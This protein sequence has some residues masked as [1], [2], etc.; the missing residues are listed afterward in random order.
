M[1]NHM[2]LASLA[3]VS[4]T[5][6]SQS[7]LDNKLDSVAKTQPVEA[8]MPKEQ[9]VKVVV[10]AKDDV[11]ITKLQKQ[12]A[13]GKMTKGLLT[14]ELDATLDNGL[15]V[16]LKIL[17]N[18]PYG[19]PIQYRSGMTADLQL[20]DPMGDKVWAWSNEM[21]FTQAIRDTVIPSGKEMT[22]KFKIPQTVMSQL[23]GKGY[24]IKAIYA[25]Q[26]IESKELAMGD[27]SLSLNDILN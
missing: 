26:A 27:I 8:D 16:S 5:A 22:V 23:K 20:L 10:L 11:D 12:H 24:T 6:C 25:G 18:Q 9:K 14:G 7:N 17:N 13:E 1:N 19:V 21:M 4:L 15:L 3:I 2:L